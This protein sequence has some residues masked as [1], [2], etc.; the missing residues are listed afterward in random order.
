MEIGKKILELRKIKHITQEELAESVGVTRQTISNWELGESSPDLKQSKELSK[1][2][3]ISLDELV[4]NNIKDIVVSKINN[5][6]K[7][8]KIIVKIL[9]IIAILL[10]LFMVGI[11]CITVLFNYFEASPVSESIGI[12]CTINNEVY[13]YEVTTDINNS[14]KITN[15]YTTDNN[16]R[17]D[18]NDYHSPEAIFNYIREYAKN[19]GGICE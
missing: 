6:E 15:F 1:V 18:I 11:I 16:L 5:T 4:D 8:S 3:N 12:N 14:H 7:L 10:L 17:I 9:K 2:F 19:S 13:I